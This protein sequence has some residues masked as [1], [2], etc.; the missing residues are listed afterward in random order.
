M[1]VRVY[2]PK[3][4]TCRVLHVNEKSD[5]D[6]AVKMAEAADDTLSGLPFA[7][8]DSDDLPDRKTRDSWRLVDGKVVSQTPK[9]KKK[10]AARA[11]R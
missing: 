10:K 4:G 5:F 6:E 1:R 9:R 11:R 8:C 3:E 7:D 2:Q